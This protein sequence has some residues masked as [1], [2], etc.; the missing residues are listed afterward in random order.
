LA[1]IVFHFP[2][3]EAE[4]ELLGSEHNAD[5]AEDQ[6]DALWTWMRQPSKLLAAFVPPAVARGSPNDMGDE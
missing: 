3:L 4:L 6:V 5:L 2:E 1:A